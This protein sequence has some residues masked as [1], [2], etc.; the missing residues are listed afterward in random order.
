MTAA[1]SLI[2]AMRASWHFGGAT[3]S[4]DPEAAMKG[5][6]AAL[7]LLSHRRV[8]PEAP[9]CRSI[10]SLAL[11]GF[12]QASQRL[13]RASEALPMLNHWRAPCLRWMD[14]PVNSNEQ[15]TLRWLDNLFLS[16]TESPT[17]T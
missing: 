16:M 6:A 13:G 14:S 8:D 3:R 1:V 12:C 7:N 2:Q 11:S 5:Y 10:I 4:R 17:S 15:Q 9:W